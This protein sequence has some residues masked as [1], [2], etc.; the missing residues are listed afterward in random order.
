MM[1]KL[2]QSTGK[3]LQFT[4]FGTALKW[5]QY[6]FT[7]LRIFYSILKYITVYCILQYLALKF[8]MEPNTL[9]SNNAYYLLGSL[10]DHTQ[11][12][13]LYTL[14]LQLINQYCNRLIRYELTRVQQDNRRNFSLPNVML[15]KDAL[16]NQLEAKLVQSEIPMKDQVKFAAKLR[17]SRCM[18]IETIPPQLQRNPQLFAYC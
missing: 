6:K 7:N 16:S 15:N 12:P 10:L 9:Y 13:L 4:E 17:K 5:F 8:S 3:Y 2:S 11:S 18:N 1:R 14:L